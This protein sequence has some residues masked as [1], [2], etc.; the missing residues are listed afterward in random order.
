MNNRQAQLFEMAEKHLLLIAQCYYK[1]LDLPYEFK[2]FQKSEW[3]IEYDE[4]C[5]WCK[6]PVNILTINLSIQGSLVSTYTVY[7]NNDLQ[8]VDEFLVTY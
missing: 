8:Y 3:H 6:D 5:I 2:Y 4:N 1:E 7:F